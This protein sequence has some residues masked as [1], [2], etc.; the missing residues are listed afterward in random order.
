MKLQTFLLQIAGLYILNIC[1][2]PVY[3]VIPIDEI[4]TEISETN[5]LYNVPAGRF[6][7]FLGSLK[8]Y[9][10]IVLVTTSNPKYN[11]AM[12]EQFD[13]VYLKI[14]SSIFKHHPS[15]KDSVVFARVEASDH[16]EH[17]KKLG[18]SSV[19]QIWGFPNSKSVLGEDKYIKVG[20]LLKEREIARIN[21]EEFKDPDWYDLGQAGMEHF[22]FQFSQG[23]QWDT[24]IDNFAEFIGQT[25]KMDVKPSVRDD[26]NKGVDWFVVAQ[27]FVYSIIAIKFFQHIKA[28]SQSDVKLWKDKKLYGYVCIVLIFI[29]LSGFN[30]TVQ[31]HVPFISQREGNILWVA[32]LSNSQFGSEIVISIAL[33][34]AFMALLI[35]CIDGVGHLD[36]SLKN[37][38]TIVACLSL[39]GM[40]LLGADIYHFKNP[41]YPYNYLKLF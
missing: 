33:Q 39:L 21:G 2:A 3:A 6:E 34:V 25:I 35:F 15:L 14:V 17:L 13:S 4:K 41:S 26:G 28:K 30:F 32:P 20:K 27:W 9:N 18:I 12:C 16:L 40:L 22:V 23:Q 7:H 10:M 24:V 5:P 1:F 8:P 11:C 31:R 38:G 19:P 37:V 29:N 36:S